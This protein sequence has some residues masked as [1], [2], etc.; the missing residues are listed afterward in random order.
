ST[1]AAQRHHRAVAWE[2]TLVMDSIR[3]LLVFV[4][5]AAL[6]SSPTSAQADKCTGA[7]L[8]ASGQTVSGALK[9][10]AKAEAKGT[11]GGGASCEAK[12]DASLSKSFTKADATGAC[13]GSPSAVLALLETCESEAISAVGASDTAPTASKCDSKKVA[14]MAKKASTK[15]GCLSKQAS[16]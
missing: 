12:A 15:L 9:C 4:L 1:R 10:D 7:K 6:V 3:P 8:K 16:K 2:A 14:A 13:P 5:A 11:P